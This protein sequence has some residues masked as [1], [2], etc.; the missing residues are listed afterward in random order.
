MA[1][2]HR[3]QKAAEEAA[4]AEYK[5]K[6][7][8][9]IATVDNWNID[10]FLVDVSSINRAP[11]LFEIWAVIHEEGE[12][13]ALDVE[14]QA[15]REQLSRKAIAVQQTAFPKLRDA[16]GPAMRRLLWESDGDARTFGEG[17][18][19]VEFIAVDFVRNANIQAF[20]EDIQSQLYKLRFTR[21]QYR[22]FQGSEITYY[23]INAPKDT[24]IV[25]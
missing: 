14:A 8:K 2:R 24:D 10:E 15:L 4:L 25:R 3:E 5:E 12:A 20:Q 18:R 13:I 11:I 17:F 23:E 7:T 22:W 1:R 19:T 6:L 9:T 16:Y 21:S